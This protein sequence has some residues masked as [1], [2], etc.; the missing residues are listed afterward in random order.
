MVAARSGIPHA[1]NLVGTCFFNGFGTDRNYQ[2]AYSW[3][4]KAA[5]TKRLVDTNKYNHAIA[6]CNLAMMYELGHGVKKNYRNAVK[7]YI[8]SAELGDTIAQNNLAGH[9][10][11]G[12]GIRQ[13][14]ELAFHWCR[15]AARK[16]NSK[17][18]YNLGILYLEGTGCKKN[19]RHAKTWLKKAKEQGHKLAGRKLMKL[20]GISR[21]QSP[22]RPS[23]RKAR[24]GACT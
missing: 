20:S 7:Y 18:Q 4:R 5:L 23:L 24:A 1:Q 10:M 17:A 8:K 14:S 2:K 12:N 19:K 6:L 9:Y 15:I 13:D 21:L 16:G 11:R 3:Y 22:S